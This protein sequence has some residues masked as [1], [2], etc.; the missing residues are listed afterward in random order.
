V[1]RVLANLSKLPPDLVALIE[2]YCKGRPPRG[3]AAET[4][5]GPC[6]GVLGALR[7]LADGS[8]ITHALG[9]SRRGRLAL[10]LVLARMAHRGSRLSAVRWAPDH[11][12]AESLGLSHFDEDDLYET[13][14]WLAVEQG[15]IE[16]EIARSRPVSTL[17]LYDVTSSSLEGQK[18]ELAAPG[19]NRDGK[20]CSPTRRGSRSRCGST[21]AT[22]PI[23]RRWPTRCASS[24]GSSG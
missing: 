18:N 14:D 17:F 2:D 16:L 23:P 22:R 4:C 13:L 24:R 21:A 20:G 19:Y 8:G 6:Y 15:R 11:A 9:E 10:F 7:A 1:H 5:V 3:D 12:V